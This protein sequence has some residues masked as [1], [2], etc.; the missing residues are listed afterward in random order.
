MGGGGGG[1]DTLEK[2]KNMLTQS[3][4][5]QEKWEA[6]GTTEHSEDYHGWFN[7]LHPKTLTKLPS[8]H[9]HKI[10]ES[11]EINNLETKAECDKFI[12][13]LNRDSSASDKAKLFAK[14]FSNNS[15]LDD[16]GICLLVS[17]SRT[18]LKLHNISVTPKMVKKVITNIEFLK[19][20]DPDCISVVVLKNC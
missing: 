10:R 2:Q 12:N 20:S 8:I 13:V 19:A 17:P 4:E 5:H 18:N 7:W 14:N 6:S 11:L 3:I 9:E 15:N 16:L 1:G